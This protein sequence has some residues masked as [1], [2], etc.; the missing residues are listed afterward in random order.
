M[1]PDS[2][3]KDLL[4]RAAD[5]VE[6][7]PSSGR[8][9]VASAQRSTNRRWVVAVGAAAV[10]AVVV[11]G[12]AVAGGPDTRRVPA[13]P[14]VASSSPAPTP[15][16]A[17][18]DRVVVPVLVK[19]T[20]EEAVQR[21][22]EWGLV[23]EVA[24][25]SLP[26][27]PVGA[28]VDQDPRATTKVAAGST[29]TIVVADRS[30]EQ[31][32]CPRGV[33]F[34]DDFRVARGLYDFSRGIGG[35]SGPWSP[36]VTLAVEDTVRT[37]LTERQADERDRWLLDVE[38]GSSPDV[39]VLQHLAESGGEFRVDIGPHPNC[40]GTTPPT[41]PGLEG[42]RQLSITPTGPSDS[43]LDWWAL[44]VYLNDV[45]QIQYVSIRQWEW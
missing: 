16:D 31:A 33:A 10:T 9:L 14:P 4:A 3:A 1:L 8:A 29:V 6:V 37:S 26:C 27:R 24:H 13:P 21:V 44:D 43:C 41:A 40:V 38:P 2:T 30:S 39:D 45:D 23:A 15:S 12:V 35:A 17:P 5:T 20:E 22:R 32:D 28:V 7:T 18:G 25:R 42:L 36:R 11:A 19:Y 34:D